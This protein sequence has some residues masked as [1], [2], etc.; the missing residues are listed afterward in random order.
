[1]SAEVY[2]VVC[3]DTEGPCADEANPELLPEWDAVDA[4]MDKLFDERFRLRH[5]DGAGGS[6]RF[7]WF[8][9]TWTG[10]VTNPRR[11]ALGYH[12]VRDHYR[13]RW[14]D[15][16]ARWGDE[17]CWH[18][19]HPP[20]SGVGNEWGL[21]WSTSD[22]YRRILSR[23][24]LERDWWPS[25]FRAGGTIMGAEASRWV[26]SWF[27]VDYTNRAPVALPGVADWADG[28]A[29]W[30][31]Y[32]P[33]PE[34]PRRPGAG[35]RRMARCL[36]L[37]TGAYRL[38][39][40]DVVAAFERARSGRPA[41]LSCFEHD[42]RDIEPRLDAFAELVASVAARYDDVRWRYAAPV[43]AVRAYLGA[44]RTRPLT[45]EALATDGGVRIWSSE[46]IFQSL[47]WIAVDDDDDEPAV[48]DDVVRV[49][50]T[51]WVWTP[52]ERLRGREVAIGASTDLG[53][54]AVTRVAATVSGI[55]PSPLRPNSIW[56]YSETFAVSSHARAAGLEPEMDAAAQ[57][58]DLLSP[59]VRPGMTVLDVG[60]AGGHLARSLD[61]LGVEY[62][63]IDPFRRAVEIGRAVGHLPEG[64]L[65]SLALEELPP[66]ERYDAVVSLSTLLYFA[67]FREPLALMAR[68]AARALVVRSCFAGEAEARYE[69]D[70]LLAP[71]YRHL[72]A[73]F[74]V[75]A[76]DDV[77]H[78]LDGEGFDVEWVEDRRLRERF[79][80]EPE[81][82]G[83][84]ALPYEFF[85]AVRRP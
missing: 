22:E 37:V 55:R 82:V 40:P 46:P 14:G 1:M 11:R 29:D 44:P 64:R 45:L 31:L 26:D 85:V 80:G 71:G 69:P 77:E 10:F 3:I 13:E 76:R 51:T 67:D 52:P 58:R 54:A 48:L 7:G 8:F 20:A 16:L 34:D 12:A 79:G 59:I 63:G 74:N 70:V 49:D 23:Q 35:R 36:D 39:E 19:H 61:E 53:E 9:L 24:L 21:D 68:A 18:Y 38:A 30:S 28:V 41:I 72:R 60:S 73:Y 5:R 25:C 78:F 66:D 15:A 2:V 17:Q 84:I 27:P 42:Y 57:A 43:E 83:G 65:R 32:H 4:A 33:S 75:F 62:H 81:I 50:P 47:P 56:E 6:L